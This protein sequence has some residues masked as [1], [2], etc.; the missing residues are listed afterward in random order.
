MHAKVFIEEL[1]PL[2]AADEDAVRDMML[3]LSIARSI[4]PIAVERSTRIVLNGHNRLEALKRL[5]YKKIP[6]WE[7]DASACTFRDASTQSAMDFA[8]IAKRAQ[9]GDLFSANGIDVAIKDRSITLCEPYDFVSLENLKIKVFAVGVFDLFHIGHLN[10]LRNARLLGEHLT[11]GV[12]FNVEA[13]K[14]QRIHYSFNER[15]FMVQSLRFVDLGIPYENVAETIHSLDFDVFAVGPDQINER[16]QSAFE[17]CRA[18][19]KRIEIVA[20]TGGVSSSEIRRGIE[21]KTDG[22]VG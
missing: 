7:V 9:Q 12:Q 22:S 4:R 17:H 1:R 8:A 6:V 20:R 2:L 14:D 16:F 18:S 3:G 5:G 13:Y 11:V 10:F 15:F 21:A 19:G